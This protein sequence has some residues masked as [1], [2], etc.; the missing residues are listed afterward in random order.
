MDTI[1]TPATFLHRL[2]RVMSTCIT[3]KKDLLS[4]PQAKKYAITNKPHREQYKECPLL[5]MSAVEN[6][7][8][9]YVDQC[10]FSRTF[11]GIS[12]L[13]VYVNVSFVRIALVKVRRVG[14]GGRNLIIT[15]TASR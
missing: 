7:L 10:R 8:Q 1:F 11:P 3:L 13:L 15:L 9:A 12:K 4:F 14:N 2:R 6:A 5:N